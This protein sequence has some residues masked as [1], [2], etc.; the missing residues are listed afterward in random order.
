MT[1]FSQSSKTDTSSPKKKKKVIQ[2]L[3]TYKPQI[4]IK[5]KRHT[6]TWIKAK[7]VL[8]MFVELLYKTDTK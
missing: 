4:K 8:E 2:K 7:L 6:K 5:N 3:Q 1:E